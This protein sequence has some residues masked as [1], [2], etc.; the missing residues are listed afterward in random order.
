VR[1]EEGKALRVT[2]PQAHARGTVTTLGE[3]HATSAESAGS[4]P[5]FSGVVDE[6]KVGDPGAV[7]GAASGDVL[8]VERVRWFS[9]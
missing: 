6:P 3:D 4:T 8:V 5:D 7:R 2:V 9:R 1:I